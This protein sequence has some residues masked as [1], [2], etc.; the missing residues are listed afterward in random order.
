M[1]VTDSAG[2][3]A[4]SSLSSPGI[5]QQQRTSLVESISADMSAA[6]IGHSGLCIC[7]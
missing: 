1:I 6:S 4:A 7:C 2:S 5:A 3:S